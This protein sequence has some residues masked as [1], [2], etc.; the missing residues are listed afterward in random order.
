MFGV[1]AL[2]WQG[3]GLGAALLLS[4]VALLPEPSP[5]T[6]LFMTNVAKS[7]GYFERFGFGSQG[8]I[9]STRAG[10]QLPCNSALLDSEAWQ[11]CRERVL[12]L[13]LTLPELLVPKVDLHRPPPALRPDPLS[14]G[15]TGLSRLNEAVFLQFAGVISLLVIHHGNNLMG[16]F[17]IAG[18]CG[19]IV[20]GAVLYRKELKR[21][22]AVARQAM[23][24]IA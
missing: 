3:R 7:K 6:R 20:W 1:V 16:R 11:A 18:S 19:L 14:I 5:S 9:G 8:T 13:G 4:R 21:R 22:K 24:G 2:A 17:L 10:I 12:A 15:L 23:S